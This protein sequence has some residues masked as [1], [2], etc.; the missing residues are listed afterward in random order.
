MNFG[1]LLMTGVEYVFYSFWLKLG[2][3]FKISL[4]QNIWVSKKFLNF[5]FSAVQV[6]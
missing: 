3:I 2:V 6:K 1:L 5:S 4:I